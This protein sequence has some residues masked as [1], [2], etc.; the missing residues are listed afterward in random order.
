MNITLNIVICDDDKNFVE[1]IY[2]TVVE[3]LDENNYKY[4]IVEFYG[5][6]E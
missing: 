1:K 4:N 6:D 2:D 5:S 3:V